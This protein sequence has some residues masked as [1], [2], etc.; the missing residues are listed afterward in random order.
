MNKN[1]VIQYH[2]IAKRLNVDIQ[3]IWTFRRKAMTLH[4][5]FEKECGDSNNFASWAIERDE[6]TD[7][8]YLVTYP[9]TGK[10]R[11]S[12]IA[13]KE[14]GA[15]KAIAKLCKEL[16]LYFFVQTDCRGLALYLS[17][18]ELTDT[19]YNSKGFGVGF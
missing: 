8:P 11:R 17:R 15:R 12:R 14:T 9:H 16:G 10:M 19:N 2:K 13:D 3:H 7:K 18:E 5:W 1:D 6:V 4:N